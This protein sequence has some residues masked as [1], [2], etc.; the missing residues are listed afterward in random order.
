MRV[1]GDR[2]HT[3]Q[4]LAFT[5]AR[6]RCFLL[7]FLSSLSAPMA[8]DTASPSGESSALLGPEF[9]A[10]L[11]SSIREVLQEVLQENPSL[12][13][14]SSTDHTERSGKLA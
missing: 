5:A 6:S 7:L 8:E 4:D 10:M 12:L 2:K 1:H 14:D 9:R 13:R 3:W 11:K